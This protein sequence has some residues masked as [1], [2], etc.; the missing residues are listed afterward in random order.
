[1][2][3]DHKAAVLSD[4]RTDELFI[5]FADGLREL[6]IV[7]GEK[8]RPVVAEVRAEIEQVVARRLSG[9]LAGALGL[10]RRAMERL[11]A[12]GSQL[13]RDEGAMM[14]AIAARFSEALSANDRATAK[15]TV[16]L[17]RRRAGDLKT[18]EPADW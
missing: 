9:D 17:M 6:E 8:A 18:D 5:R 3:S 4:N 11:A 2:A 1:M 10:I 13:D 14:R 16:G 7:I 15:E 12:L